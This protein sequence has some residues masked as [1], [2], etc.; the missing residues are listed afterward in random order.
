MDKRFKLRFTL[1]TIF[2]QFFLTKRS[3][4][5]IEKH[6]VIWKVKYVS[7]EITITVYSDQMALNI[8]L[9]NEES[10]MRD[11]TFHND[12]NIQLEPFWVYINLLLVEKTK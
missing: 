6:Q 10:P 3:L 9:C 2:E 12:I 11:A 7:K 1:E 8:Y 5:R 4:S